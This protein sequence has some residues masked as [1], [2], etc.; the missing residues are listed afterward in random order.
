MTPAQA[1]LL[2]SGARALGV[3]LDDA[4]ILRIDRHLDLLMLWRARL[5]LTGED[6]AEEILQKHVLDSLALCRQIG[7]GARVADVG[8]GGGF[9]GIVVAC[10]RPDVRVSLIESRRRRASFLAEVVRSVPLVGCGVHAMRAEEAATLP[11][12]ANR[13]DV[14]T[15]RALRL[16]QLLQVAPP[17]L[18]PGGRV[19]AMQT[20]N[21]DM[22]VVRAIGERFGFAIETMDDYVLGRGER[23]RLT[24]L[25]AA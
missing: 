8:S 13:A 16:D 12:L 9:P 21:A 3:P 25:R 4:G 18:A 1:D 11:E 2:R 10:A 7:A 23:R 14:V 20:A 17:L 19:I 5:R 6:D 15:A 24:I 22:A